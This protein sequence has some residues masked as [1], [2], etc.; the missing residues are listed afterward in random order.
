M[1]MAIHK[2]HTLPKSAIE[3]VHTYGLTHGHVATVYFLQDYSSVITSL[4]ETDKP[5]FFSL[6]TNIERLAQQT[7]SSK[8]NKNYITLVKLDPY[9]PQLHG[10]TVTFVLLGDIT[11][12]GAHESRHNCRQI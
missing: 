2:I 4:P 10:Y 6:P 1:L 12:E 11:T 9:P 5:I 7:N 8:V 3:C